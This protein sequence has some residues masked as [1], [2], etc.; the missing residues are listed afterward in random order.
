M[1]ASPL[2]HQRVSV[3]RAHRVITRPL[4][5]RDARELSSVVARALDQ[6][7]PL[8]LRRVLP[9]VHALERFELRVSAAVG[10]PGHDRAR[11]EDVR[12]GRE[13]HRA[14]RATSRQPRHEDALFVEVMVGEHPVD[15]RLDPGG[16]SAASGGVRALEPREATARARLLGVKHREPP[17]VS[18]LVPARADILRGG[19]RAP[20]H[21]DDERRVSRQPRRNILVHLEPSERW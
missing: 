7:S 11:A 20:V 2:R 5:D 4:P 6:R 10:Q 17:A 12:V 16:L 15:H 3:H 14:H 13:H 8:R 9:G 21:R 19:L 1:H 18:E